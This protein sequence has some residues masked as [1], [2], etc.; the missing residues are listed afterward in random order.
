MRIAKLLLNAA[1]LSGISLV[2]IVFGFWAYRLLGV[3][4]QITVQVPVALVF[5]IA[6]IVVWLNWFRRVHKL[7]AGTDY[8]LVILLGIPVCAALVAGG[9]YL[10]TGY[11]TAFGNIVG[12]W[13]VFITEVLISMPIAA[14]IGRERREAAGM[15][16]ETMVQKASLLSIL[17]TLL[18]VA[19]CSGYK[20]I[21]QPY[22]ITVDKSDFS[23]E[24]RLRAG[25]R[26]RVHTLDM[27]SIEG[28]LTGINAESLIVSRCDG[29]PPVEIL[30]RD[31]IKVIEVYYNGSD[32][33]S[34]VLAASAIVYVV[35]KAVMPDQAFSP[36]PA[37]K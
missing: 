29:K 30:P 11:L 31:S 3:T 14:V 22:N 15:D 27:R 10:V 9:H 33:L 2:S 37:V 25:D 32:K 36:D 26:V 24:T 23:S 6:S 8:M 21:K 1:V 13:F 7:I 18:L 19:G 20:A 17:C 28:I 5:G 34:L 4:N 16:K 12:A 35:V